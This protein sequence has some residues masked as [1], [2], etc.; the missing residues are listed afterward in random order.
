V[1]CYTKA[2]PKDVILVRVNGVGSE[3]I[4]DREAEIQ[5]FQ[6]LYAA[7]CGP[8]LYTLFTNGMAYGFM[9]GT[10]LDEDNVRDDKV[11]T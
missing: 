3:L 7:K 8:P 1:G 5:T 11:A 10:P 6:L 9:P 4:I 2:D